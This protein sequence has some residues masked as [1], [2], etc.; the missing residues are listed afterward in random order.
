MKNN[1]KLFFLFCVILNNGFSQS[2][3]QYFT[4][5]NTA[6]SLLYLNHDTIAYLNKLNNLDNRF[7][8][9]EYLLLKMYSL[10]GDTT[11]AYKHALACFRKGCDLT[12]AESYFNKG[13]FD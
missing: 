10:Q 8:S 6:D 3:K 7:D 2:F 4:D 5:I 11:N 9:Q 12:I 13:L 1:L